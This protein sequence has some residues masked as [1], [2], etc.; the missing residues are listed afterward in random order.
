[1]RY[2]ISDKTIQTNLI[3]TANEGLLSILDNNLMHSLAYKY[4]GIYENNELIGYQCPYSGKIYTNQKDIILE[5]IIPVKSGGGTVLFN[6]IPASI[7]TNS[8]TEKGAKHLIEWWIS[9]KYW[10]IDAP[11]RL[12]KLVNYILDG[13]E[14]VFNTYNIDELEETYLDYMEEDLYS[15]DEDFELRKS[16][17]VSEIQARHNHINSYQ[18]FLNDCIEQ[19]RKSKIDVSYI[20]NRLNTIQNQKHIFE[21]IERFKF[22]QNIIKKLIVEYIGDDNRSYL[23]YALNI[24]IKK[25]MSSIK[26]ES[27]EQIYSELKQRLENINDICK[28]NGVSFNDYLKDLRDIEEVNILYLNQNQI[29]EHIKEVFINN[30]KI[31]I[32]TK[33]DVFIN[34]L[35]QEKYTG[36]SLNSV[37][38]VAPNENNIFGSR[39]KIQFEGYE[40]IESLTTGRFWNSHSSKI[41]KRLLILKEQA[42]TKE[43]KQ[44]YKKVEEAIEIYEFITQIEK[45][46]DIFINML[47]QEKYTKY[48]LDY[49][50][51]VAPDDNNVF[52]GN[53]QIPFEGYENIELL[54]T[55]RFWWSHSGDVIKRLLTLKE[56]AQTEEEK[57]KYKKAEEAIEIYEFITQLEKRIDI[58]INMLSQEK[59]TGYLVNSH[60]RLDPDTNNI[61]KTDNKVFFEGYEN[62]EKL[63]IGQFWSNN[64]TEIIK[65]L[66]TLKEQAQTKEEKQKYKKAEEAIEIYE[67]ITQLEKRIDIFINMLSQEKYTKYC[68]NSLGRVAPNDNNIF[69]SRNKIQFEGYE[70]IEGLTT[71]QFWNSNSSK[72]IKRLLTLK[73]QAQTEEEKQKYKKAEEAIDT[74]NFINQFERKIN[75]FI[76]MLLQEKYTDYN[77]NLPNQNNIFVFRNKIPFEGYERIEGLNTS[78]FWSNNSPSIIQKL[79][80]DEYKGIFEY[81]KAREAVLTYLKVNTIEEYIDKLDKAKTKNK[82]LIELRNSQL[83]EIDR[84]TKENQLLSNELY[85]EELKRKA[86]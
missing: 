1:M 57:Q 63:N 5:H 83:N 65:R 35:S 56:Q 73:E 58:F 17:L 69:G 53:N 19:L 59:Y 77:G 31:G 38:R 8:T 75:V 32:D 4:F 52:K 62:I 22:F 26:Q 34:M 9:S 55:G 33:I 67:F 24:N 11:K 86:V 66:L 79:F 84:L 46:I 25:L 64:S 15:Y 3:R 49:V 48:Y 76:N 16:D 43:E 20:E 45:R 85:N 54:T 39:N 18:G 21:D 81:N 51:R 12:E 23:T 70:N 47:S 29:E 50:G 36:Y 42:A 40:N 2:I 68:L 82:V 37:G 80:Y 78:Q 60:G 61:L 72:I 10:D 30:I 44:K 28:E 41:I 13:Y 7:E 6:C 14:N 27:P 71:Y 74:Y